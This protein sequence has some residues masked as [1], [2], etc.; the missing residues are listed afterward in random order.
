MGTALQEEPPNK[1]VTTQSSGRGG[2]R[3]GRG[4]LF[5]PGTGVGLPFE[6]PLVRTSG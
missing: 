2:V 6:Q 3:N 1:C 5:A 4:S